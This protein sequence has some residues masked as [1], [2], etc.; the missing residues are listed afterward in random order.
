MKQH[1][2]SASII[3]HQIFIS[4]EMKRGTL[5]HE[6]RAARKVILQFRHFFVPWDWEN[7]GPAGPLTP[8]EYCLRAVRQS[9]ALV[10]IVSR[11]LTKHTHQEYNVARKEGKHLFV[12]FKKGLQQREA[13]LFRRSLTKPRSPSWLVFQNASELESQ[14]YLSLQEHVRIALNEFRATPSTKPKYKGIKS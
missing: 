3:K 6:R 13:L 9:Y 11:T 8:I 10:L 7:D 12:F 14:L 2:S 4:S 5:D 1:N